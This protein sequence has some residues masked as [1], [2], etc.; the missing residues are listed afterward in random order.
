MSLSKSK[1]R[2]K[3][4]NRNRYLKGSKRKLL[5]GIEKTASWLHLWKELPILHFDGR[6]ETPFDVISMFSSCEG[7]VREAEEGT[8]TSSFVPSLTKL[9]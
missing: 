3:L 1:P 9:E 6:P 2:H 8:E 4:V 5:K 7:R